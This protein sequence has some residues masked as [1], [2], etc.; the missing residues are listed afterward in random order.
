VAGAKGYDATLEV[1]ARVPSDQEILKVS[2]AKS[3]PTGYPLQ[4]LSSRRKVKNGHRPNEL[5]TDDVEFLTKALAGTGFYFP[6]SSEHAQCISEG[7]VEAFRAQSY[8]DDAQ[9]ELSEWIRFSRKEAREHRD[10][11]TTDSMEIG[12][13]AG[14]YVR[15]F[16]HKEDVMKKSFREKVSKMPREPYR[17]AADG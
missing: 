8:R 5:K 17:R 10:G 6:R 4:R 1:V 7:T 13:L 9:R 15:N 14:W 3:K 16:M 11:M 2:L 12:G